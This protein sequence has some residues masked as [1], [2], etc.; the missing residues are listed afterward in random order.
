MDKLSVNQLS[1]N[2][3]LRT[4]ELCHQRVANFKTLA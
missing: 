4:L 3:T 1:R 2:F